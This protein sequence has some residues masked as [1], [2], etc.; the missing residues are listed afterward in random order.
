MFMDSNRKYLDSSRLWDN[1]EIVACGSIPELLSLISRGKSK[2]TQYDVIIIHVGV[3]DIDKFDGKT[4]AV[5]LANAAKVITSAAPQAKILLSEV[6]PRQLTKDDQ[7]QV[8]N[9]SLKE[10]LQDTNIDIIRHSNLRNREWSFHIENDDKHF[11]ANSISR[12]AG[13]L[14]WAFRKA[15]GVAQTPSWKNKNSD[16]QRNKPRGNTHRT[17]NNFRDLEMRKE[18][19]RLLRSM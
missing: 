3:N 19:L 6:T 16:G 13:N 10:I 2:L 1:L 7:V 18:L 4:V 11:A 15:I 9:K 5:K 12:L 17:S 14:K 8:C